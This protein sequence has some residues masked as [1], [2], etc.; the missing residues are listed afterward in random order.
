MN[1][2][3]FSNLGAI[4][5]KEE[6]GEEITF[7]IVAEVS[8]ISFKTKKYLVSVIK[9]SKEAVY[10]CYVHNIETRKDFLLELNLS[11]FKAF[12]EEIW[13]KETTSVVEELLRRRG[14]I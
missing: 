12:L 14:H 2:L 6:G 10:T 5:K 4:A 1:P 7:K 3:Y 8:G 9:M 13:D 11:E